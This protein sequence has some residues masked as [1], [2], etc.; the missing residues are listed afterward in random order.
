MI[1][2][3]PSVIGCVLSCYQNTKINIK[4]HCWSFN[5]ELRVS[6]Q[7]LEL[8]K[9]C[10]GVVGPRLMFKI[11]RRLDFLS[12]MS[13]VGLLIR[14]IPAY[15]FSDFGDGKWKIHSYFKTQYLTH[16]TRYLRDKEKELWTVESIYSNTEIT[17][18]RCSLRIIRFRSDN[19]TRR[20][21]NIVSS[22]SVLNR[23]VN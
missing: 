10:W 4:T 14:W 22:F 9:Y 17:L 5:D 15:R 13:S 3:K 20:A 12:N 2:I 18:G 11:R 1:A 8:W 21:Y 19:R 7:T 16:T 23:K 6:R